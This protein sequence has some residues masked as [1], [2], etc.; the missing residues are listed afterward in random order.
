M[1]FIVTERTELCV[2]V[3]ADTLEQAIEKA[4][5]MPRD[6]WLGSYYATTGITQ[7][8]FNET[9][10]ECFGETLTFEE[11]IALTAEDAAMAIKENKTNGRAG[12]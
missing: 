10:Q 5:K 3:A 7:T 4:Q 11:M 8:E 2:E 9:N 6:Q 12:K 1:G